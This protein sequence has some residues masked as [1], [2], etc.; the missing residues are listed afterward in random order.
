MSF[1]VTY[2][3]IPPNQRG[4]FVCFAHLTNTMARDEGD[5]EKGEENGSIKA[6]E[7]IYSAAISL[8]NI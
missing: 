6:L 4:A 3:F 1:F 5:F 7:L 8:T 2:I